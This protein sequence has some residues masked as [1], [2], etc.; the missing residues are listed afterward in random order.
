MK[1]SGT[2]IA[3]GFEMP[4]TLLNGVGSMSV[5]HDEVSPSSMVQVIQD[6]I[7]KNLQAS[8]PAYELETLLTGFSTS[9][10]SFVPTL[11]EINRAECQII[12]KA[13]SCLPNFC[14]GSRNG[15]CDLDLVPSVSQVAGYAN[16]NFAN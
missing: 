12:R 7:N 2:I 16:A 11:V 3:K 5:E 6:Q 9:C 8:Y 1:L 14:Q 10:C 4:K 13:S 15:G